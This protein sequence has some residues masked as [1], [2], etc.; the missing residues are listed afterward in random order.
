MTEDA[1]L[2]DLVRHIVAQSATIAERLSDPALVPCGDFTIG[3]ARL[4]EW[5]AR[6][7]PSGPSAFDHRLAWMGTEA[8]AVAVHLGTVRFEGDLPDWA[9]LLR[10]VLETLPEVDPTD[11][12]TLPFAALIRP[13]VDHARSGLAADWQGLF[14]QDAQNQMLS[15]LE[16]E[17]SHLAAPVFYLKLALLRSQEAPSK[18]PTGTDVYDAFVGDWLNGGFAPFFREYAVLARLLS[19]LLRDWLANTR[20]L[21]SALQ[22]DK[23][24]LSQ[25]FCAG[26]DPGHVS[27]VKTSLSDRHNGG[28]TV[29][30]LTFDSGARIVFKP[31]DIGIEKAWFEFLDWLNA[32]GGS[33]LC[34][35][36]LAR[37]THGWVEAA[38]PA[39]CATAAEVADYYNRAGQL[40]AVLYALE[41]SDC[42]FENILACGPYPLLVD[43]ET[44]MHPVLKRESDLSPAEE[45]A[46]DIIFNSVFRAGFL[47]T[48]EVEPGGHCVDISGLGATPGQV[49]SYVKRRWINTNTD[50]MSLSN[51]QI[52]VDTGDHLPSLQ[53]AA[54]PVSGHTQAVVDGFRFAYGLLSDHAV[55]LS[56]PDG[57]L[58][59]LAQSEIRMVFHA[60]RIYG[61]MLKRLGAPRHLK[62]GVARSIETDIFARFYLD[63]RR[64]DRFRAILDAELQALARLDIPKF[65][66]SANAR[67]LVLPTGVQLPDIY[68]E[69]AIERVF[70]RIQGFGQADLELQTDFIRASLL[71]TTVTEDHGTTQDQPPATQPARPAASDE[72][73]Q[74]AIRIAAEL[75]ERCLRAPDGGVTWIAPQLLPGAN[76]HELRPLRMDLYGGLAGVAL[77]HAGLYRITGQGRDMALA[78]AQPLTRY[79]AHADAARM[80]G[81]GYTLGAATGVG[82]FVYALTQCAV[83]LEHPQLLQAANDAAARITETWIAEDQCFD[84]MAGSAGALLALL[85]LHDTQPTQTTLDRAL[86]CGRHLVAQAEHSN[87]ALCWPTMGEGQYLTGYSH[88]NAGIAAALHRL[89]NMSGDKTFAACATRALAFE[90]ALYDS[91]A[92]NW[93]DLREAGRGFMH[94]WCH[95]APGIGMARL[96]SGTGPERARDVQAALEATRKHGPGDVDGLCCGALGRAELFLLQTRAAPDDA[97][98][99]DARLWA[100]QVLTRHQTTG[101]YSLTGK[102]G[103]EF[104]DPSFFR[105]LSGIG[106]QFLRIARPEALPSVLTWQ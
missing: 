46:D 106:Y 90:D 60:T 96:A 104:F 101:R 7:A 23:T 53:G 18:T 12:G 98:L 41:A 65:T 56:S 1:T 74:E 81:D 54:A 43:M 88:G 63:A 72:L 86:A 14:L 80:T 35:R 93:P 73:I 6:I 100:G 33:F 85:S 61:L 39:P 76:R 51:E 4:T 34:L 52:Q 67:D 10:K 21:I 91:D 3:D 105:G 17:L 38:Q 75:E 83:L 13:F 37:D 70:R 87:G 27:A 55:L 62:D 78:A 97:A 103:Q 99:H 16:N 89:S 9:I 84:V 26:K 47:P 77:F 11:P 42:F 15:A 40:L 64:K 66:V 79:T 69:A 8:A 59:G 44:L 2:D 82:S 5:R 48:W 31:R 49:T 30:I 94:T 58:R 19:V 29:S 102:P 36:V 95:G 28:K 45:L 71:L 50:A 20:Q 32:R 57:P 22:T 68:E 25:M 92:G 24:A